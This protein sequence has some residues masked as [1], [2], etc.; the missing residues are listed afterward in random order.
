MDSGWGMSLVFLGW[1]DLAL[2]GAPPPFG[3]G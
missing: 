1:L 3:N 2:P